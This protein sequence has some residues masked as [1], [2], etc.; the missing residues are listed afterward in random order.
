MNIRTVGYDHPD[1]IALNRQVQAEYAERYGEG[2]VSPVDAADFA[3]PHGLYLIAYDPDGT[4]IASGGWR[5]RDRDEEGHA[6]GDAEVKRMF[7]VRAARG[8]G[9]ARLLLATLEDSARAAGRRRI[10]METGTRQPEAIALYTSSGYAPIPKFGVYRF[11]ESS[12]CFGKLLAAD[13][14]DG[15]AHRAPRAG[16]R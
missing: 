11:H 12:R 5:C 13:G 7:V 15:D 2:D 14:E 8:R 9:L 16:A 10:I 3:P 6:D 1:A 4:P